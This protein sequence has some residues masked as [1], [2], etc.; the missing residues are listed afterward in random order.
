MKTAEVIP[1]AVVVRAAAHTTSDSV[2]IARIQSKDAKKERDANLIRD[3]VKNPVIESILWTAFV[4]L[5]FDLDTSKPEFSIINLLIPGS[6]L[7]DIE[8]G[9]IWA[10]GMSVIGAQQLGPQGIYALGQ[11]GASILGSGLGGLATLIPK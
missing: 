9:V 2:K 11:A 10:G 8:R 4:A 5:L 3:L 7:K 6:A 1:Q